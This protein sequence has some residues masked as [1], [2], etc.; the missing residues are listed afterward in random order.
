MTGVRRRISVVAALL[1]ARA[2]RLTRPRGHAI[3]TA[4]DSTD[5]VSACTCAEGAARFVARG[6]HHARDCALYLD[7]T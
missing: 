6:A 4:P 3:L 7:E 1:M 5:D 2:L